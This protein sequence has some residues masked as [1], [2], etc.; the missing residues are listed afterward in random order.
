MDTPIIFI[1]L[2]LLANKSG[3]D[4]QNT[5]H[6]LK[7]YLSNINVDSRYTGEKIRIARKIGPLLPAEYG[8]TFNRSIL[9]TEKVVRI[10]ELIDFLNY[11]EVQEYSAL[12]IE[13]KERIQRIVYTLQ[14]EVNNSKIENLGMVLNIVLNIDKYKKMLSTYSSLMNNKNPLSDPNTI[15]N[16]METFM[17]GSSEKDKEKIKEMSKMMDIIKLLDTPKKDKP[18]EI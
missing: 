7:S 4:G 14:N 9:I 6:S 18:N 5:I 12:E 13:P 2:Y 10:M 17:E 3:T 8:S 11:N 1:L 16:L 15:M